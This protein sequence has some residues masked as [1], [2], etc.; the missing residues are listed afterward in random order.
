MINFYEVN[1]TQQMIDHENLDVRTITLGIS[2]LDC[3][4]SDLQN[5][6]KKVY[7]KITSVAKDLVATGNQI[8]Q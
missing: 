8:E 2:L 6:N 5:L 1:E 4:D 3:I 7:E